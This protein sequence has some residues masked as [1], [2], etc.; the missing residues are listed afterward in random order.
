MNCTFQLDDANCPRS[1]AIARVAQRFPG[2]SDVVA[3]DDA[4]YP[5]LLS[6]DGH[7]QV[8]FTKA[9]TDDDLAEAAQHMA[10]QR[11]G[12]LMLPREGDYLNWGHTARN[13]KG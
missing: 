3:G 7:T 2:I 12:L 9:A 8:I 13:T 6:A 4:I 10:L 1:P 5:R 11:G